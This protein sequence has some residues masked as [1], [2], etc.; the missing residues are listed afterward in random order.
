MVKLTIASPEETSLDRIRKVLLDEG[1]YSVI[2]ESYTVEI[3]S[4]HDY[5]DIAEEEA[6]E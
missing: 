2:T 4:A 3:Q 6:F 5:S 1:L